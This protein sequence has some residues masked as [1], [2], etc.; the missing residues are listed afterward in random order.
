M[1]TC[2]SL[3]A[4]V[5]GGSRGIG[6]AI[7]H[8]LTLHGATLSICARGGSAN[9]CVKESGGN[10]LF[11]LAHLHSI[12]VHDA[13]VHVAQEFRMLQAAERALGD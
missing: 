11:H 9:R 4:V 8:E 13:A 6:Y 10:L 5:T 12:V 2:D 3:R 1:K 7:A